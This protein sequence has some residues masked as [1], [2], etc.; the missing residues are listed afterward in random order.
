MCT[1]PL[2]L[3]QWTERGQQSGMHVIPVLLLQCV[4]LFLLLKCTEPGQQ[5]GMR[6]AFAAATV[7]RAR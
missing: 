7:D 2:L 5:P 3:L 6:T 4:I 1:V